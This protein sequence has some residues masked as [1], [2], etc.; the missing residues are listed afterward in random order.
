MAKFALANLLILLVN[1]GTLLTSLAYPDCTYPLPPS[2]P[3]NY[4][5]KLPPVHI[6]PPPPPPPP[7]R[8]PVTPP[9]KP[10]PPR[11]PPVTPPIKPP[12][13]SLPPLNPPVIPKPPIVKPPP[14]ETPC[15]PH[16]SLLELCPPPPPKQETCPI[17]TLKLGACV[18]VLGGLVH[19]RTGSSAKD[20]CCPVL[21]G[22]V[23]FDVASCLCTV[24]KAKLL[25]INLIIPIALEVLAD[26]GKT[27][28]PGF[29]CPA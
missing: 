27:P 17:N 15:P 2:K 18:D 29:K 4:P 5:P 12:P 14:P 10:P 9:I 23:D 3:P 19:I 24:I 20:E 8:P 1:S 11:R 25:N 22:L 6:P 7:L 26:C 16:P 28:P 21:E 13:P